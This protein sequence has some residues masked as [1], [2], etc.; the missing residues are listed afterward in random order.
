MKDHPAP[1]PAQ[2]M[3]PA[4]PGIEHWWRSSRQGSTSA[5]DR[6]RKSVADWVEDLWRAPASTGPCCACL[7]RNQGVRCK[8]PGAF[9]SHCGAL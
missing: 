6:S 2:N 1:G 7:D 4:E 5:G 3:H 8:D 9:H